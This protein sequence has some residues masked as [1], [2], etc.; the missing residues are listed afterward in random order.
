MPVLSIQI[1]QE[2]FARAKIMAK[3]GGFKSPME[4]AQV[5]VSRQ[6]S[7]EESPKIKPSKIIAEMKKIGFYKNSFLR[8]LKHSLEHADK[9]AK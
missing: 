5:L 7:L 2:Q 9:T 8:E 1:P 3:R 4:W 6:I